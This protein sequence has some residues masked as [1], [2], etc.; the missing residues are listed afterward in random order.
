MN[1]K[2]N[3]GPASA[4]QTSP[5]SERERFIEVLVESANKEFLIFL[6]RKGG[7]WAFPRG[8]LAGAK[9]DRQGVCRLNFR[10]HLVTFAS[11]IGKQI[12]RDLLESDWLCIL[13]SGQLSTRV[14]H[15]R[16]VHV[17]EVDDAEIPEGGKPL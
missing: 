11:Q 3:T 10:T 12:L 6:D 16:S 7:V 5:L 9:A 13:V 8:H 4:G 14:D 1:T 17:I 2:Q 15:M